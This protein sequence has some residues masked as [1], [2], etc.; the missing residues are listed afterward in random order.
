MVCQA[1]S[2]TPEAEAE[3]ETDVGSTPSAL[4]VTSPDAEGSY[5]KKPT[6]HLK[7]L[8][9]VQTECNA[10]AD[11]AILLLLVCTLAD[12][13]LPLCPDSPKSGNRGCSEGQNVSR[14]QNR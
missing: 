8:M 4:E 13:R 6:K 14:H 5:V 10:S 7:N 3:A 1:V 11:L 9:E 12:P 2:T